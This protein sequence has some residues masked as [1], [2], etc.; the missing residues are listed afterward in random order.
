MVGEH[1]Q[2]RI[3][4]GQHLNAETF[5]EGAR[6]ELRRGEFLR[7]G[8]VEVFG[9]AF[10]E[11]FGQAEKFL[12]GV[13]EPEA[14]GGAAEEV[15][16][17]RED[18]PD[19]ARLFDLV[20]ANLQLLQGDA[21]A[22]EHAEDIVVGLDEKFDRIGEGLV[23]REPGCLG[24]AMRAD[25]GQR[26]DALIETARNG[27]R[28]VVCRKE[29]VLVKKSHLEVLPSACDRQRTSIVHPHRGVKC[30]NGAGGQ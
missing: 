1:V 17:A 13:V 26:T 11:A 29:P 25:D 15:V 28:A 20:L 7:D 14:R 23:A 18:A 3:G 19:L 16:M 21:L 22:V 9:G 4:C 12:K 10:A 6:Q 30:R 2:R 27:P 24:V 5:V 8:V